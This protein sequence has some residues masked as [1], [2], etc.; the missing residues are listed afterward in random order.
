MSEFFSLKRYYALYLICDKNDVQDYKIEGQKYS[1]P[2]FFSI[3]EEVN[4]SI[5]IFY[6]IKIKS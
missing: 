4:N 5:V 6:L 1:P 3:I 2:D